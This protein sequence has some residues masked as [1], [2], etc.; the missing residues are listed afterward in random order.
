MQFAKLAGGFIF[1]VASG[2][3]REY[4]RSL[5]ADVVIDYRTSD[6][7]TVAKDIDLVL[8][9]VGGD[10]A[11][12]SFPVMKKG[13]RLVSTVTEPDAGQSAKYGVIAGYIFAGP[14]FSD[15][16]EITRLI[17]SGKVTTDVA[18]V[19]PVEEVKKAW[20]VYNHK[21][22]PDKPFSHGKIVLEM[23]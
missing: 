14:N 7:T 10:T 19:H 21:Q 13:G 3:D 2:G 18:Q 12:R 9:F 17:E 1:A 8:D 15:L 22:K 6:F 4:L 16:S 20:D 23:Q 11:S 5:G